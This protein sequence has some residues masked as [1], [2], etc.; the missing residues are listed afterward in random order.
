MTR[1]RRLTLAE[2]VA[3]AFMVG[4]VYV[5]VVGAVAYTSVNRLSD[6][7]VLAE[8]THVVLRTLEETL[9]LVTGAETGSRGYVI[10]GDAAYLEPFRGAK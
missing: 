6:T 3:L 9:S 5:A 8:R 7:T 10:T 4:V 1:F 2:Q